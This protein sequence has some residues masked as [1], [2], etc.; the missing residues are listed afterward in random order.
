MFFLSLTT[1]K[2]RREKLRDGRNAC[3]TLYEILKFLGGLQRSENYE[4]S[5]LI[6]FL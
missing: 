1:P 4:P 3:D 6:I 5:I 2:Q